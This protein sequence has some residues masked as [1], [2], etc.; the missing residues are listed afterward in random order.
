MLVKANPESDY[1]SSVQCIRLVDH[2]AS[3]T[4]APCLCFFATLG[5]RLT[6]KIEMSRWFFPEE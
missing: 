5:T 3:T 6:N 1:C 4:S 2:R